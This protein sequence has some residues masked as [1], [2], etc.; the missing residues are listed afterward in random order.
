MTND[1]LKKALR[2]QDGLPI[3]RPAK[4]KKVYGSGQSAKKTSH[5]P[6]PSSL[7]SYQGST[8]MGQASKLRGHVMSC[9]IVIKSDKTGVEV[10][11]ALIRVKHDFS[12]QAAELLWQGT[13]K[14][15]E[16]YVKVVNDGV[17]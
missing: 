2:L 1:E 10:T 12:G 14:H 11:F 3:A 5:P 7:F 15:S 9:D 17:W 4:P 8:F 6:I 16:L 13:G